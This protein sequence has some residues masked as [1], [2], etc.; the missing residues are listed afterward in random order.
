MSLIQGC[1]SRT[2]A[3]AADMTSARAEQA[4]RRADS[5]IERLQ[6]AMATTG[7]M[8][9]A[10]DEN[11]PDCGFPEISVPIRQNPGPMAEG[12]YVEAAAYCQRCGWLSGDTGAVAAWFTA[13]DAHDIP[14]PI[15]GALSRAAREA[16]QS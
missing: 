7:L 14:Y 12:R 2:A 16:G 5:S 15:R 4:P 1:L 11:C 6:D 13:L 3:T 10:H 8:A 9:I